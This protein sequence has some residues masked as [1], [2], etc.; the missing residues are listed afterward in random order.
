MFE[1]LLKDAKLL[2]ENI[3]KVR[4][5]IRTCNN[6]SEQQ[7][8]D[9]YNVLE[10]KIKDVTERI[11]NYNLMDIINKQFDIFTNNI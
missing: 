1:Y 2:F 10:K 3:S 11:K 4:L 8:L 5:V 7:K 6:L 9:L